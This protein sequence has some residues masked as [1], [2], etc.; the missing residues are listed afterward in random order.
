MEIGLLFFPSYKD[1]LKLGKY[2][3]LCVGILGGF[4][5]LSSGE[6]LEHLATYRGNQFLEIHSL[7]ATITVWIYAVLAV[8]FTLLLVEKNKKILAYL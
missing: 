1:Q 6:G 5:A 2:I 4:T 3:V 8:A 7:F